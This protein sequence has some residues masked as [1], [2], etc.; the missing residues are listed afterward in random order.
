MKLFKITK[1]P[2]V[3]QSETLDYQF[4]NHI[5]HGIKRKKFARHE[6]HNM[7]HI[8]QVLDRNMKMSLSSMKS[9]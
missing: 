2:T 1:E 5:K 9:N 6:I 8:N 4:E 3:L 7:I